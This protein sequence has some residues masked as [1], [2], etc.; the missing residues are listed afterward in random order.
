VVQNALNRFAI[1]SAT[2]IG[3]GGKGQQPLF[4][5]KGWGEYAK[6]LAD[7]AA[8]EFINGLNTWAF[9][10]KDGKPLNINLCEPN[11]DVKAR[12]GLGLTQFTAPGSGASK[13]V[14]TFSRM[15]EAWSD[16]INK[17]KDMGSGDFLKKLGDQFSPTGSDLTISLSLM[18]GIDD[19]KTDVK[20]STGKE[21]AAK[22]GWLDVRNIGGK[23]E[24][25]PDN[26]KDQLTQAKNLQ[27][28][29]L[30]KFTGDALVDAANVFLNQLA[31]TAFNNLTG[32]LGSNKPKDGGTSGGSTFSGLVNADY[33]PFS[34]RSSVALQNQL[35]KVLK[36]RFDTRGDY[37]ILAELT[38]CPGQSNVG[39]TNCVIDEQFRQAIESN[40]TVIEGIKAGYLNGSWRFRREIDANQGYSL[41]SLSIL[42]KYRI[43]PVGW[44]TALL[45]AEELNQP[46][47]LLDL[48]SCFDPADNYNEFSQGFV[49]GAWCQGLVDPNWVLKAPL[50]YCKRQ[51]A[52]GQVLDKTFISK[53]TDPSTGATTLA[54]QVIVTRADSYCADEQSCIKEK[55]DGT[56]EAYG[57]CTEEKRTWNF[58]SDGCDPVLNTCK[59]FTKNGS[60]NQVAYLENTLDYSTCTSD[61]VGCKPYALTGA[62]AS[63][64]NYLSWNPSQQIYFNSKVETCDAS[65]ESCQEFI[66]VKSNLGHN[67]LINSDFEA[68]LDRGGWNGAGV[69]QTPNGYFSNNGLQLNALLSRNI[70]V[71]PT[72][73]NVAGQA[74]TFSF[75]AKNCSAGNQF[76]LGGAGNDTTKPLSTS[77][78]WNYYSS[79]FIFPDN[80][81]TNQVHIAVDSNTCVVDQMK[82]ELGTAGTSY[83]DYGTNNLI[84]QKLIPNYLESFCYVNPFSGTKDFSLKP[85]APEICQNFARKCNA[86][87]V[88]CDLF[89]SSDN[90]KVAAKAA[91]SDYCAAQ[92]VGYDS[93]IQKETNFTDKVAANFIPKTATKCSATAVGCSEFTNLDELAQGGEAKEYHVSLRQCIK[94]DTHQCG[95]FYSW[96]NPGSGGYQLVAYTLKAVLD[97]PYVLSDDSTSC[98]AAIF[99]LP[100][101]HPSY[102]PDCRQFYNKAGEVSYHLYSNTVSCSDNCHPYRLSNS[103]SDQNCPSGGTWDTNQSA[104][105]YQA[106]PGEGQSCAASENGCREYN[107]NYGNNVRNISIFSF[108]GANDGWTG[109]CQDSSSVDTDALNKNGH[110]LKYNRGGQSCNFNIMPQISAKVDN[111]VKVALKNLWNRIA[112]VAWAQDPLPNYGVAKKIPGLKQG[113]S[114]TVKFVAKANQNTI[115]K[116][117]FTNGSEAQALNVTNQNNSDIN[118]S[119]NGQWQFYQANLDNLDHLPTA[120]ESIVFSAN[121]NFWFDNLIITEITN[122][123]YLIQ[124]SWQTPD[125]CYYDVF[126]VYRGANYNLGCA[127]YTDRNSTTHNLRHFSKLCGEQSVGCELLVDTK[128]SADYQA[129]AFNENTPVNNVCDGTDGADCVSVAADQ[130]IYA[131]VDPAKS[132]SN[133]DKGCSRLGVQKNYNPDVATQNLYS[134]VYVKN[135][136]DKYYE[137]LCRSGEVGCDL[138][139]SAD[140]QVSYFRDPGEN[141]C[142]WREP[143]QATGMNL[144]KRWYKKPIKRCDMNNDGKI[145]VSQS[146][147]V[148]ESINR[149]CASN[150]DCA[151]GGSVGTCILDENDYLCPV[152]GLKTIGFGGAGNRVYQPQGMVGTCSAVSSGCSEYIDPSSEFSPNIIVNPNWGDTNKDNIPGDSWATSTIA[153]TAL[154]TQNIFLQ[155]N[156]LYSFSVNGS[157]TKPTVLS[158]PGQV[159]ILANNNIFGTGQNVVTFTAT[160][161]KANLLINSMDN[162]SCTVGGAG[163]GKVINIRAT[164]IGYQLSGEV[165]KETC[166][167]APSFDSGCI[168]FN[169]RKVS[170]F[171]GLTALNWNAYTNSYNSGSAESCDPNLNNCDSNVLVKVKPDRVCNK[172]LSCMS[173]S[174]DPVTNEETCYALGEC[175]KLSDTG[176]CENFVNRPAQ[177]HNFASGEDK[178]TA[179]Y[180]KLGYYYLANMYEVGGGVTGAWDFE[181]L[182][183]TG[184]TG[185]NNS[186]NKVIL[187]SE[188][189]AI[190]NKN[191]S[192]PADGQGFLSASGPVTIDAGFKASPNK[193]YFLSLMVNSN[194]AAGGAKVEIGNGV[195]TSTTVFSENNGWKRQVIKFSF[196]A[197]SNSNVKFVLSAN[198]G[199]QA[200]FDNINMDPVLKVDNNRYLPKSCRLYPKQDS[201]TCVSK[202]Q[203]TVSNGLYGYCLEYDSKNPSVCL[204]WYPIDNVKGQNAGA[205]SGI[206]DTP[207][208][209]AIVDASFDFVEYRQG[210]FVMATNDIHCSNFD[211]G[212]NPQF[213]P[214]DPVIGFPSAPNPA[215]YPGYKAYNWYSD[216]SAIAHCRHAIDEPD[217]NICPSGGVPD[218]YGR[219]V[220]FV[221]PSGVGKLFSEPSN[222]IN[223]SVHAN[224][225]GTYEINVS[226]ACTACQGSNNCPGS[227]S[228]CGTINFSPVTSTENGWYL[229]DGVPVAGDGEVRIMDRHYTEAECNSMAN[230]QW[231]TVN[232]TSQ[233]ACLIKMADYKPRCLSTVTASL[234]WVDRILNATTPATFFQSPFSAYSVDTANNFFGA[235]YAAATFTTLGSGQSG[236]PFGCFDDNHKI[237]NTGISNCRAIV[238][239]TS[240]YSQFGVSLTPSWTG[241]DNFGN[242]PSK[243]MQS[244]TRIFLKFTWGSTTYDYS[245]FPIGNENIGPA[246]PGSTPRIPTC[247]NNTRVGG[248]WCGVKPTISNV[249]L[250]DSEGNE[251]VHTSNGYN[252]KQADFYTLSFN[253]DVDPEQVPIAR[254]SVDWGEGPNRISVAT[255]VDEKPNPAQTFNFVYFYNP[256]NTVTGDL[257]AVR[258][259]VRDNWG[260]Y[261]CE[262][263][264]SACDSFSLGNSQ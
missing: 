38:V 189:G 254:L 156:K 15:K 241:F 249:H 237:G 95:V 218:Y 163:N 154:Q 45:K 208:Y 53:Q 231:L 2:Y 174:I 153:G 103:P 176:K 158:C 8:G 149:L 114:Y 195:S 50:N 43:V 59:A 113:G 217:T 188:D 14:C 251:M 19:V 69:S 65:T 143:K 146:G 167:G 81:N 210:A 135:N 110:S 191:V 256:Q 243:A 63:S 44:E 86:S 67:I 173:K 27:T 219:K 83:S 89:T 116:I 56:C 126:N 90:F 257:K 213:D 11:L 74:Y 24:A 6:D 171:S 97:E 187:D 181:T 233:K 182:T 80:V 46:T 263:E 201:L 33:D 202:N 117:K 224:G 235:K 223:D 178:N 18:S 130:M 70:S 7:N 76:I 5:T 240:N 168:M 252:I 220:T 36:P 255:M 140:G 164:Q 166:N 87:E 1:D 169:E 102:N 238:P 236:T 60:D 51:G 119:G 61:N 105:I 155:K 34:N 229:Y 205:T 253:V 260:F 122:R 4:V 47:T 28:Q 12:I 64:T 141:V 23:Q 179:G 138:W 30:G 3:S 84:Y 234:A 52:G 264:T 120:D 216:D 185:L 21:V 54:A 183:N 246:V 93:Y 261:K 204:M 199:G 78:D 228:N 203:N 20:D 160:T 121:G 152:D 98:N 75:Y 197:I 71:G 100:P 159:R 22:G 118:I 94:P 147:I 107:G 198:G 17:I 194:A 184:V 85:G 142:E 136:P 214:N 222:V 40:Q 128:N 226:Q 175:D 41:R 139:T 72:D 49:P 148:T 32:K 186:L 123:Y 101:T 180:S 99:N 239:A 221:V 131:I 13:P 165:D 232:G 9:T 162:T 35:T 39:P 132:C 104:C 207:E 92:C 133:T 66:K 79:T 230:A 127:S 58:G 150:S 258:I 250:R 10:G 172:W 200:F 29:S 37:D 262:N 108:E 170:G 25:P 245:Q 215:L 248:A 88:G 77:T 16:Q 129:T 134:D 109:L 48:V 111:K 112:P 73:Y 225:S 196:P 145:S 209:C 206:A 106:I 211:N 31:I 244:L 151:A 115:L 247:T 91:A 259:G 55:S 177:A 144:P 242:T 57:Y 124:D 68:G 190:L 161:T 192:Y 137:T 82:L 42:R 62:Y 157:N 96:G 125:A 212:Y 26:S 227:C 193:D